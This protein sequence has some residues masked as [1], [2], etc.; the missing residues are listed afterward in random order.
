MAKRKYALQKTSSPPVSPKKKK[1]RKPMQIAP[2]S[3]G[4]MKYLKKVSPEELR[5]QSRQ[6]SLR[7]KEFLHDLEEKKSKENDERTEKARTDA[8]LRKAKQRERQKGEEIANGERTPGG[9]KR[10]K[11]KVSTCLSLISQLLTGP[12]DHHG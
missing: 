12:T 7:A 8:R 10:L 3:Q 6:M 2:S 1:Q 9:T 11:R 4:I 5:A